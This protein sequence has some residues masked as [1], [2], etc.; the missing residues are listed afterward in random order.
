MSEVADNS[1][2]HDT[3]HINVNRGRGSG[4]YRPHYTNRGRGSYHNNNYRDNRQPR[5]HDNQDRR[6]DSHDNRGQ[7]RS[8]DDDAGDAYDPS[9]QE[10]L[11]AKRAN[12]NKDVDP[13]KKKMPGRLLRLQQSRQL[14]D[15]SV[16]SAVI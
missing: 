16:V 11:R 15:E 12:F 14:V 4:N 8:R 7:K 13:T 10:G 5:Y 9:L 1:Y 2:G 6:Y 3:R